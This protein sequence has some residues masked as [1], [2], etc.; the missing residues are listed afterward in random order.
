M[1]ENLEQAQKVVSRLF[2]PKYERTDKYIAREIKNAYVQHVL[3]A[4]WRSICGEHLEK[5]C[6]VHKIEK[7]TLIIR[8]ASSV[9]AN[10]LLMM[11][12]LFLQKINAFLLGS[13]IIKDIKFYSGG[14]I[15]RYQAVSQQQEEKQEAVGCCQACG[16]PVRG[17]G[18]LCSVCDRERRERQRATIAELLVIQPWLTYEECLDYCKCDRILFTA[19][20]DRV[21]NRYFEKVRLGSAGKSDCLLAVMFLTGRKPEE[22]DEKTYANTLE[23]LRRDQSVPASGFRLYGKKQRDHR[24]F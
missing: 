2:N 7:N 14:Q 11:K 8:T 22:I 21:R 6:C 20:R 19:V 3:E 18:S 13:V 10:H 5:H 24:H 17:G 23:Y 9:W 12:N 15:R 4:N 1:K 16:V